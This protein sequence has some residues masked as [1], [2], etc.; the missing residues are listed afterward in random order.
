M[1]AQPRRCRA[2]FGQRDA[3]FHRRTHVLHAPDL[4]MVDFGHHVARDD[5]RIGQRLFIGIDRAAG[6]CGG[7][8]LGYPVRRRRG[9]EHLFDFVLQRVDIFHA[10]LPRI[11]ARVF[12]QFRLV[13]HL[14][15]EIVPQ[16]VVVA[17]DGDVTVLRFVSLV[18]RRAA[19]ARAA[20]QR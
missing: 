19:V 13:H 12:Q 3:G 8:Q 4:G 9:L 7:V 1:L 10:C 20:G 15:A 17:A 2:R 18:G 5:V 11:E 6:H 16:L 14:R